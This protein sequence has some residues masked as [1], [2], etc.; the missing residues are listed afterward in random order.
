[1]LMGV[2][3]QEPQY[4]EENP[5]EEI[6]DRQEKT[7]VEKVSDEKAV[8][9]KASPVKA[10]PVKASTAGLPLR[11]TGTE[12]LSRPITGETQD[13]TKVGIGCENMAVDHDGEAGQQIRSKID[14]F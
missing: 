8:E 11:T 4:G 9:E 6:L 3:H 1:M 5:I 2:S 10:S 14:S 13:I 7:S 12:G